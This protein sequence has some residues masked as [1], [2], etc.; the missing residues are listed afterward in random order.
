[1][2]KTTRRHQELQSRVQLLPHRRPQRASI[3]PIAQ[4]A[5]GGDQCQP[6]S[7]VVI[8][9]PARRLFH[10]RFQVKNRLPE[11]PMPLPRHFGQP[12]QQWLRFP[13]HQLGNYFLVKP[14]EQVA[15]ARQVA[16]IEKRNGEFGVVRIKTVAFRQ[17]PRRRAQLELQIPQL[18]RE[19][20]N[21]LFVSF[22]TPAIGVQKKQ[23]NI[24][25][26]EEP[27]APEASSRHQR[28]VPRS[29][30]VG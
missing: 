22:F 23:V 1:M 30:F 9:Q 28:K 4:L 25:I 14:R 27:S 2:K 5:H 20:P 11:F 19:P 7:H 29:L 10:I 8:A 3:W 18:L 15:V 24:G 26:R 12:L 16:A 21:R 17:R 6:A 13:H